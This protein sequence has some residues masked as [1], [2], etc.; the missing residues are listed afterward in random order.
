[1][2]AGRLGCPKGAKR[3]EVEKMGSFGDESR[4]FNIPPSV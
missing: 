1:L 2:K 3:D 4:I